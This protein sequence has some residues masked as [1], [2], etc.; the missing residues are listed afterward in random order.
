MN[1]GLI[2]YG[3]AGRT[4]HAPVIASV[5]GLELKVIVQRV[6][7]DATQR[8]P[9]VNVVRSISELLKDEDV[10]L[11]VIATPNATHFELAAECLQAG[12][13][14]V[15][16]KPF[17]TTSDE[18]LRLIVLAERHN[19]RLTAYHNR[20]WDGDFL[21]VQRLISEGVLGTI[22]HFRSSFDRFR[23]EPKPNAW[24]ESPGPGSGVLFDLGPH[25]L[26]QAL[27]LFGKPSSLY[28]NVRSEREGSRVDDAF[29]IEL[30]YSEMRVHLGA[31]MLALLPR[32]RFALNGTEGSF[33]KHGL[34]PQEEALRSGRTPLREDWGSEPENQWGE[35]AIARPEFSRRRLPTERGDYKRFYEN[36]RDAIDGEAALAV[37]PQDAFNV[38]RL[39]ELAFQ[40]SSER[41]ALPVEI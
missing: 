21:T 20:R 38:M 14:V 10:R 12:R 5:R 27:V 15:I 8:Y 34:D 7:S 28:A 23:P 16:D 24:R 4:F 9:K 31:T 37:T 29:D 6:A 32:P 41:R 25:L 35:V 13:H 19:C 22:V 11:V 33:V 18:A 40:S 39:L 30:Y 3:F 2:G 36:V 26:D 1:V 17:T